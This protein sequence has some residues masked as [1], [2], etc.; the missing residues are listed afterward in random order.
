MSFRPTSFFVQSSTELKIF[1]SEKVS[2]LIN[3]DNFYI[4][5]ISGSGKDLEVL[6]VA[7]DE[8]SVI[9][10]TR[11][12]AP[13]N[14]YLLKLKD[15]ASQNFVS[16]NGNSLINDDVSRDIFFLGV[17]TI[18]RV[19]DDIIAKM[20]QIYNVE[21]T[22]I[23]NIISNISDEIL[24]SQHD[25]GSVLNSNYLK[26]TA[27]EESRTRNSG[28]F[29]RLANENC[30]EVLSVS[31]FLSSQ[32]I[33]DGEVFIESA[34]NFPKNII[35]TFIESEEIS[36]ET[37]NNSFDGL[38][39]NLSKKFITRVSSILV[40]KADD[41]ANCSG[42]IGTIYDINRFKYSIKENRY[43]QKNSFSY[44]DLQ[45]NQVL[46]SEF[47]NISRLSP[48]DRVYV[49]YYY[50]DRSK[51]I[52]ETSLDVFSK[53][54][55]INEPIPSNSSRFFLKNAPIINVDGDI[56]TYGGVTFKESE[57]SGTI[58]DQFMIEIPFN[59]AKLPNT[60]GEYSVNYKTG[61]VYLF[62]DMDGSIGTGYNYFVAD[63]LYKKT[64]RSNLDYF[65]NEREISFNQ[66][67]D[68]ISKDIFVKYTY[69]SVFSEGEDYDVL[70]H[71]EVLG[72]SVENRLTSS[73]SIKT[74]NAQITDVFRVLNETTGEVYS[75]LYNNENEIFISGRKLPRIISAQN[76]SANFE[77]IYN[78]PLVASGEFISTMHSCRII[79]NSSSLS[80]K[81]DPPI[82]AEFINSETSYYLRNNSK[83][84]DGISFND[85]KI[86]YFH[87]P[88]ANG[89]IDSFA[90]SSIENI[91][92]L[93][94]DVFIGTRIYFFNLKNNNILNKEKDSI[95]SFLT[96]SAYFSDDSFLL[97]KFFEKLSEKRTLVNTNL[98]SM[99]F[100]V[101]SDGRDVFYKNI[102]R[103]RSTGDYSIDYINGV[104]YMAA[105]EEKSYSCGDINYSHS[106][107]VSNNKN[108]ISFGDIVKKSSGT[109]DGGIT[110]KKYENV[111]ID[112]YGIKVL[113]M[114]NSVE[115]Y[116]GTI[117]DSTY[118]NEK[119][120]LF[121]Y[122]DY[123]AYTK[124]SVSSISSVNDVE[125]I[126]G[127]NLNGSSAEY[128]KLESNADVLNKII[129]DSGKN[130]YDPNY[131]SFEK[132]IIDFKKKISAKL[133]FYG[134]PVDISIKDSL[135]SN[136]YNITDFNTD[137]VIMNESGNMH[138][139]DGIVSTLVDDSDPSNDV[140]YF[141]ELSELYVLS[142][143]YD[144]VLDSN[145]NYFKIISFDYF[146]SNI[147]ISKYAQN[148]PAEQFE[149]GVFSII[150]RPIINK[151][152]GLI[153]I[154]IPYNFVTDKIKKI[155]INCITIFSP[156][157]GTALSINYRSGNI[158]FS[159][160]YVFDS[161][162]IWYEYGDNSIDWS[163]NN[164]INEGEVYYVTYNYGALRSALVKNF[165]SI[166]G[167]P[168][169]KNISININR[170]VYRD[171]LIGVLQSFP[172]G[173]TI[174]AI[175]GLINSVTKTSPEINESFFGNW[176][177]GRDF[178]DTSTVRYGG[179]LIFDSAK[180]GDGLLI[181]KDVSLS[182]PSISNL[183][184]NEGTV[185]FWMKPNWNGIDNDASLTF[186]FDNI[187]TGIINYLGG[188][189]PFDIKFGFD[190]N[191]N[192]IEGN[193]GTDYSGSSLTIFK[194]LVDFDGY[195]E[196]FANKNFTVF[197]DKFNITRINNT[198]LNFD[199]KQNYL[200]LGYL[201]PYLGMEVSNTMFGGFCTISDDSNSI[202][203]QLGY[204]SYDEY[205]LIF[206]DESISSDLIPDIGFPYP[207]ISC[208][209]VGST[210]IDALINFKDLRFE[211]ELSL[212]V[213]SLD[214]IYS[215][216]SI[217]MSPDCFSIIDQ[218]GRIYA[219]KHF[220]DDDGK[221]WTNSVPNII[222][223]I[224]VS[225]F[226]ENEKSLYM[227]SAEE[228]NSVQISSFII[229]NKIIK[230]G[231]TDLSVSKSA[232]FFDSPSEIICNWSDYTNIVLDRDT[233]TNLVNLRIKDNSYNYFYTDFPK[234]SYINDLFENIPQNCF[235]FGVTSA[236]S[237][238][239]RKIRFEFQNKFSNEDI[240]IGSSGVNPRKQS[241]VLNRFD[242][243]I[244]ASGISHKLEVSEGIFIGYDED[245]K[246]KNYDAGQWAV[247]V[248]NNRFVELPTDVEIVGDKYN[249]VLDLFEINQ[250]VVGSILTDGDFL[251]I[252]KSRRYINSSCSYDE[253]CSGILRYCAERKLS[254][255][256]NRYSQIDLEKVSTERQLEIVPWKKI[257]EFTETVSSS[258]LRISDVLMSDDLA[259]ES[260]GIG[261]IADHQC[262][263]GNT[264][265]SVNIKVNDID[266]NMQYFDLKKVVETTNLYVGITPLVFSSD[267]LNILVCYA[268]DSSEL[269]VITLVD[270]VS[271]KEI[272]SAEF[273][274]FD[275][276]YHNIS[277]D[278]NGSDGLILVNVDEYTVITSNLN[279]FSERSSDET[280]VIGTNNYI[281]FKIID[282]LTVDG[283]TY[284]QNLSGP[285][286]DINLI[287]LSYD[288]DESL[289]KLE[290]S[291]LF[292]Y[293]NDQKITFELSSNSDDDIYLL[294]GYEET[295]DLDEIFIISDKR[296][297]LLDSAV[298][299]NK[300][301]IS[302]FK[303]GKGFLNFRINDMNDGENSNLY[304]IATSIRNFEYGKLNHIAA[305][306]RLNSS[307]SSDE[308]HLFVNGYE[309]PNIYR[310]GGNIPLKLNSKFSDVSQECL[311]NY[312]HKN[313]TYYDL[314]DGSIVAGENKLYSETISGDEDIVSRGILLKI[315]ED[316]E[317]VRSKYYIISYVG[318]GYFELLDGSH[319]T[320]AI[321][322]VT[323][324]VS[325]SFPPS[326]EED[327]SIKT[328]IKN[329]RIAILITNCEKEVTQVGGIE[330][331]VLSNEIYL[332]KQK[333][334][335]QSFVWNSR[336]N[337]LEFVRYN[338]ATCMWEESVNKTDLDISII[339][340]GLKSRKVSK[341]LQLSSSSLQTEDNNDL[342]F[343]FDKTNLISI[344]NIPGPNP[345]SLEDI[346]LTKILIKD[347]VISY[348]SIYESSGMLVS[349]FE[350]NNDSE[351]SLLSSEILTKEKINDGR[352]LSIRV[353]SDNI[354][355]CGTD[356][357]SEEINYIDVWGDNESG[358]PYERIFINSNGSFDTINR[359]Y[360]LSKVSGKF[361]MKD[362][363]YEALMISVME[364]DSIFVENG[365]STA[366]KIYRL[367]DNKIVVSEKNNESYEPFEV[368]PGYYRLVYGAALSVNIPITG[369]DLFVGS[370]Y[371]GQN[372]AKAVFDDF[373][374]KNEMLIDLKSYEESTEDSNTITFDYNKNYQTCVSQN[375]LC[376]L[377]L[378][379]PVYKQS[380]VLRSSVFF[381]EING[382]VEKLDTNEISMLINV[383][384]NR[385]LF[386]S[387]LI[388]MG[389]SQDT[390]TKTW[391]VTSRAGTGAI[392]NI[393]DMYPYYSN[394]YTS[395]S[396][397]NDLFLSSGKFDRVGYPM[398][399]NNS[400]LRNDSS[401][402]EFW[403]S[404]EKDTVYD[405]SVRYLLDS[406]SSIR[407][408]QKSITPK[409]IKLA[410]PASKIL[411]IR[412][413]KNNEEFSSY[414]PS[415]RSSVIFDEITRS[416]A[417]GKLFGGTGSDK[418]F[419]AE[420]SLS[421]DGKTIYL[422]DSLPGSNISVVIDYIPKQFSGQRISVFKDKYSRLIFRIISKESEY[423]IPVDID[424][425]KNTWHRVLFS[426]SANSKKDFMFAIVDG[427]SYEDV[428]YKTASYNDNDD[429][430]TGE[431]TEKVKLSL[432][433][434][435]SEIMI[436]DNIFK[437]K[438]A[439]S[440][441][442]NLRISRIVRKIIRDSSGKIIDQNYSDN[443][444]QIRPVARDDLTTFLL[445][446]NSDRIISNYIARII[447]P[448]S[449][450]FNFDVNVYDSF[451]II[452]RENR[453]YVED[454]LIELI[455]RLKPSHS[456]A[457]INFI[458]RYC[459]N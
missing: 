140:I 331:G 336:F 15:S 119:E 143:D 356:G 47:G 412:L 236:S 353:D 56:S 436:G 135:I 13:N 22:L 128:R 105:A 293:E 292:I 5:S 352:Y 448:V 208:K 349:E 233:K 261:M 393:A 70:S 196:D 94:Q 241:F 373:V 358:D 103:L 285:S 290:D 35:E 20:P 339:T 130:Y 385:T 44:F 159:Y 54:N 378:D 164:S 250:P 193:Y 457:I 139:I 392:R 90:V 209:C 313:I 61:E 65:S 414:I 400:I 38:L 207:T 288:Y 435:F 134:M 42:D 156:E 391:F 192:I 132:N 249:L 372:K 32:N 17:E 300:S 210:D 80:I 60:A 149:D 337:M 456:N 258:S 360:N 433:E 123:T 124:Y 317:I 84:S 28:A 125:D 227:R 225:R 163:I 172:K 189:N 93:N 24:K 325:F 150:S 376:L 161:L 308:M 380:R 413:L 73:F 262:N 432:T 79:D 146:E 365:L 29:D 348:D 213:S 98:G 440:R 144:Y 152:P 50:E 422:K 113:N 129:S 354:I 359:F 77:S 246:S 266:K 229:V 219:V 357:Y 445:E 198:K 248:R 377:T 395:S 120:S 51:K 178:L 459:K 273:D 275:F 278:I 165:G 62:G 307:D 341:I 396:G 450:I 58:P 453:E 195:S 181:D 447:D 27:I 148:N 404:P 72:E 346:S 301:R 18:N 186:N 345:R 218:D 154:S 88:D 231:Y 2:E 363:E 211:I 131:V 333:V 320:P 16:Y 36:P 91:P 162:K 52:N 314:V 269:G 46:L 86:N 310:F 424:W 350:I 418:D 340:F 136:V 427:I 420:C 429:Y 438:I 368:N 48:G 85:I 434:Q 126:F 179:N 109:F 280:C 182:V 388:N 107:H 21:G 205:P 127:K 188:R 364:R 323:S 304:N 410:A 37:T 361:M 200:H 431:L 451:D 184:L 106:R 327:Y 64:W 411:K 239:L 66:N 263:L 449:G 112:P 344:I 423:Y 318:A 45:S 49:S 441:I 237:I 254:S 296:R 117:I 197:N 122:G 68:A 271:L 116:D 259:A 95:G 446:F 384:N 11:P 444:S 406:Y 416:N 191:S 305:S 401:T 31:R 419:S 145:E 267:K 220:V 272:S 183:S 397:P 303:D 194:N 203:L 4:E 121:V 3:K 251:S 252:T 74:K 390:A 425:S 235:A 166:T 75:T 367:I 1:F 82:P 452:S 366:A 454:L 437:D 295:S 283:E 40:I 386:E 311:Q 170:E 328:D 256:W 87:S 442:N 455:N 417:S 316:G 238:D 342:S 371:L 108:V 206:I 226:P 160:S 173:P 458:E 382:E 187:G 14:Y 67:R 177:L 375:I 199:I 306:W 330:L 428:L 402:L 294:D 202:F 276:K 115:I 343:I 59:L 83:E 312:L 138:I 387:I 257:G 277:L 102:S 403:V 297:Y 394:I 151:S 268:I 408:S 240:Y 351:A 319:L 221:V 253:S 71:K 41:S 265:F 405:S 369:K 324:D 76:E 381:N 247:K 347:T 228:I 421:A 111:V 201:A 25:I 142:E 101:D 100:T 19:R 439:K 326:T 407:I 255:G 224:S 243:K 53:R 63:Y 374:V 34:D 133:S 289:S 89:N 315:F 168:K 147:T 279:N 284:L 176:V 57:N 264:E 309:A 335:N 270:G 215:Q 204:K 174:P 426:Y 282:F 274:W 379:N 329:E 8:R 287:Q 334:V 171:F 398:F 430:S 6:S 286:V 23:N 362:D 281:G 409:I 212:P 118:N 155:N 157:P 33:F 322:D 180:F 222:T 141:D 302:L 232:Q 81:I 26:I 104:V 110:D 9:I 185:S 7:I 370:D 169:L 332:S 230:I 69:N 321:F 96:T 55:I 399:N 158:I 190:V 214:I 30:Y 244:N 10:K 99:F 97:E 153:S 78:E 298:S 299:D 338:D 223:K 383:V 245:C 389:Y 242:E 355:F 443:I 167:I 137:E 216:E 260:F 234:T 43:D 12:Q 114:D 92:S 175:S 217:N 415:D 291:D 39:L